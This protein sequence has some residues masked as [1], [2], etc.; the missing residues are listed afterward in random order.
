MGEWTGMPLWARWT[1]KGGSTA[2]VKGVLSVVACPAGRLCPPLSGS[3]FGVGQVLLLDEVG[4][5]SG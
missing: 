3:Q 1:S 2:Q 4:D 5:R